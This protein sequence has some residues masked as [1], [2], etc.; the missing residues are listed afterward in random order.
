MNL[1]IEVSVHGIFFVR[2]YEHL[3]FLFVISG[4]IQSSEDG[5]ETSTSNGEENDTCYHYDFTEGSLV[6]VDDV[7]VSISN[8]CYSLQSPV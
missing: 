5:D 3:Y 8:S 2:I 4:I 6:I 7:C 1:K